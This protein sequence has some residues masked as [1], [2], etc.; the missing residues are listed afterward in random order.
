M[1]VSHNASDYLPGRLYTFQVALGVSVYSASVTAPGGIFIPDHV[2]GMP[3]S[4]QFPGNVNTAS[5]AGRNSNTTHRYMTTLSSPWSPPA[6]DLAN[7]EIYDVQVSCTRNVLGAFDGGAS[8][9]CFVELED[10]KSQPVT[11]PD[12][13]ALLGSFQLP[14]INLYQAALA[15]NRP[16][17]PS[18]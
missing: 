4:W 11:N 3:I 10:E 15:C 12:F 13:Q 7:L 17:H 8:D 6:A 18:H 14:K 16:R 5:I 1:D 9:S 2:S